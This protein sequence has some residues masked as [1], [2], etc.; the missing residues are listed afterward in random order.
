MSLLTYEV[1]YHSDTAEG[2]TQTEV[3]DKITETL[4]VQ[5]FAMLTMLEKKCCRSSKVSSRLVLL[6][7]SRSR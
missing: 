5:L 2:G 1:Y 6:I 3:S 7:I 4:K